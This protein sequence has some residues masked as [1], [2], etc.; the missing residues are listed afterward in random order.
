M[1]LLVVVFPFAGLLGQ[2]ILLFIELYSENGFVPIPIM[3]L[4]ILVIVLVYL[5]WQY[6]VSIK[7]NQKF[8]KTSP[9][10]TKWFRICFWHSMVFIIFMTSLVF[11]PSAFTEIGFFID[12]WL[13]M[14]IELLYFVYFLS[15]LAAYIYLCYFTSLVLNMLFKD[16]EKETWIF[17]SLPYFMTVWVFPFGIPFFNRKIE[18]HYGSPIKPKNLKEKPT[19]KA[20]TFDNY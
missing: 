17:E 5:G 13:Y 9:L 12:T 4:P 19:F 15:I 18:R 11:F 10:K 2:F 3:M 14:M 8:L 6:A 1:V 16:K 7:L 20:R